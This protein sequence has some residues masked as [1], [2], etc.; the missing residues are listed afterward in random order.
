MFCTDITLEAPAD[1][2][3]VFSSIVTATHR[4]GGFGIDFPQWH[5]GGLGAC[6]R[7]CH[8]E[9]AAIN[10]VMML[11]RNEL[12]AADATVLPR[13]ARQA[14]SLA[15]TRRIQPHGASISRL[16]R[17]VDKA[18]KRR[19]S[20]STM[21]GICDNAMQRF[22][23]HEAK[24]SPHWL[25]MHSASNEHTFSLMLERQQG[26]SANES[27]AGKGYGFGRPVPQFNDEDSRMTVE[28]PTRETPPTAHA[29][30]PASD[31]DATLGKDSV[32]RSGLTY[33]P[34]QHDYAHRVAETLEQGGEPPVV[35]MLEAETGTGKTLGYLVPAMMHAARTGERVLVST[36]TRHLQKQM[37]DKD[38]PLAARC[39]EEQTGKVLHVARR[40]GRGGYFD[41]ER[42]QTMLDA[43]DDV[44]IADF[45]RGAIAWLESDAASGIVED[46]LAQSGYACLPDD[47]HRAL[48]TLDA[49][50]SDASAAAYQRDVEASK[51]ADVVVVNHALLCI[52][53]LTGSGIL[54]G[55]RAARVLVADEADRMESAASSVMSESLSVAA[56][57]RRI[58]GAYNAG[59]V[60]AA[61]M[62]DADALLNDLCEARRPDWFVPVSRLLPGITAAIHRLDGHLQDAKPNLQQ[63]CESGQVGAA[64]AADLLGDVAR[65][66]QF[67]RA[68]DAPGSSAGSLLAS[69]SP[70]KT[71]PTLS[72]GAPDAGRLLRHLWN[73]YATLRAAVL[74][75]ATLAVPGKPLPGAMDAAAGR[76]GLIR[77]AR[78]DGSMIHRV[79]TELMA[80]YQQ[81]NFGRMAFV[82]ADRRLPSPTQKLDD[83][84]VITRPEWLD[85][86]ASMVAAAHEQ[87]GRTLVLAKSWKDTDA[88]AERLA[89]QIDSLLVHTPGQP[90]TAMLDAYRDA[91]SAVLVSPSA[92]EG[93]DLP[94]MVDQ[95]V[96]TRAPTPPPLTDDNERLR[97]HLEERGLGKREV[98]SVIQRK[99]E[100]VARNRMRQGIGRGVR[101]H[102]DSVT[103]W[104]ADPRIAAPSEWRNSLEPAASDTLTR[105]NSALHDSIPARFWGAYQQAMVL[106]E[107]GTLTQPEVL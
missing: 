68:L 20:R 34:Y 42:C 97:L 57:C 19:V 87:G 92:W 24:A 10:S 36:F 74:T 69:W 7:L 44:A 50:S 27:G 83:D 58:K 2:R 95:L 101:R 89:D 90:V 93:V 82:L 80:R 66:Q 43:V 94:G 3:R 32:S 46:Y 107:G 38:A 64:E 28:T 1:T 12:L 88:L 60:S 31:V 99:D 86:C 62:A 41:A 84:S 61:C 71:L 55:E 63:R 39:V 17:T 100:D 91:E 102:D 9:E 72:L 40:V 73:D 29:S 81:R 16:R 35:A 103:V 79:P 51:E 37:L 4:V 56:L 67:A 25:K 48:I 85:Y 105:Q 70:V 21:A 59:S 11:A 49:R 76:I 15:M 8:A 26:V 47:L 13:D 104:L 5:E 98:Q 22:E 14:T 75:S 6:V 33:N 106:P 23:E 77:H 78:Q 45:L 65:F 54:D 52:H 30:V 96:I 53:A 18:K